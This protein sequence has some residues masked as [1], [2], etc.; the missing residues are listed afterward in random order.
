[1]VDSVDLSED[2]KKMKIKCTYPLSLAVL[3]EETPTSARSL[4]PLIQ[5][6]FSSEIGEFNLGLTISGKHPSHPK[7]I[8]NYRGVNFVV[9]SIFPHM[10]EHSLDVYLS[11]DVQ[12]GG[13]LPH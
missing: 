13:H 2:G 6:A 10:R 11:G 3:Q 5:D 7:Y 1:M 4:V 8:R 9:E 12:Q